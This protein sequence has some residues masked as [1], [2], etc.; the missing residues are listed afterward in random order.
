MR[1]LVF[2]YNLA[3]LAL[4]R[5]AGT[6]APA[7]YSDAGNYSVSIANIAGLTASADASLAVVPAA[8]LEFRSVE[9]LSESAVRL[10][11]AG[12]PGARYVIEASSNLSSWASLV[13][14][15]N[16]AGTVEYTDL[17]ANQPST[18]FYRAYVVP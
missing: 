4:S 14:L 12:N 7:G 11:L 17:T 6:I 16:L 13:T 9:R 1:A 3:R 8:P 15:T 18:L 5:L 10:T 2:R